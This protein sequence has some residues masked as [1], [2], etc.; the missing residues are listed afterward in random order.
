MQAV[1]AGLLRA[2]Y[3]RPTR[4]ERLRQAAT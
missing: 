3:E 2:L 1:H 4:Y